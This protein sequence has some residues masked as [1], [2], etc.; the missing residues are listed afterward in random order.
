M[1]YIAKFRS[2]PKL[3]CCHAEVNNDCAGVGV[4]D[5]LSIVPFS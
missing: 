3:Q 5:M 2:Q 4:R 1:V